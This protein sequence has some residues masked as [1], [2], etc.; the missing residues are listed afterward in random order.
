MVNNATD[1]IKSELTILVCVELVENSSVK[2]VIAN[3]ETSQDWKDLGFWNFTVV[4][5]ISKVEASL[6]KLEIKWFE[7]AALRINSENNGGFL[8]LE[9]SKVASSC[10]SDIDNEIAELV[11][12]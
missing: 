3:L 9:K 1:L 7:A 11:E 4:V 12:T 5:R 8:K 10:L 2:G 6:E